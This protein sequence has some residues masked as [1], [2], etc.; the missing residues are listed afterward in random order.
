MVV[1]ETWKRFSIFASTW[2]LGISTVCGYVTDSE[3]TTGTKRA[4]GDFSGWSAKTGELP[5]TQFY[6][7]GIYE[8]K[9]S[10]GESLIVDEKC[11]S[12]SFAGGTLKLGFS[13]QIGYLYLIRQ[14]PEVLEVENADGLYLV[15]G[16]LVCRAK[17]RNAKFALDGLLTVNPSSVGRVSLFLGDD[18]STLRVNSKIRSVSGNNRPLYIGGTNLLFKSWT[19]GNRVELVG[20][21]SEFN[22]EIRLWTKDMESGELTASPE[23]TLALGNIV[24]PCKVTVSMNGQLEPLEGKTATVDTVHF[25]GN[26]W[27]KCTRNANK[28]S[29]GKIT[30]RNEL[31]VSGGKVK[32]A[33]PR[34]PLY[35]GS[36]AVLE[37]PSSSDV[38]KDDFVL[39]EDHNTEFCTLDFSDDGE[40]KTLY[41]KYEGLP[42]PINYVY[43]TVSSATLG[44]SESWSDETTSA[45]SGKHY[46]LSSEGL[47]DGTVSAT[48]KMPADVYKYDF[49]GD[50]LMIDTG[51]SLK[52][53][54][55]SKE[56]VV[57]SCDRLDLMDGSSI[58]GG[59]QIP[60]ELSGEVINIKGTVKIGSA[61]GRRIKIHSKI[62]GLGCLRLCGHDSGSVPY[63]TYSLEGNNSDFLG[64]IN[65][66]MLKSA[67]TTFD[68]KFS[69]LEVASANQ[70][71]GALSSLN[72]T[73]LLL[74]NYAKV[75]I[76][77]SFVLGKTSNRGVHIESGAQ[78]LVDKNKNGNISFTMETPLSLNG[79]LRKFG[80]GELVLKGGAMGFGNNGL[81]DNPTEGMNIISVRGGTLAVGSAD[82]INGA[83]VTFES[84]T[85]FELRP[86]FNDPDLMSYGIRNDKASMPFALGEN[87][88][89]LPFSIGA[90]TGKPESGV[91]FRLGLFT[92]K[93]NSDAVA[94][95]RQAVADIK[96]PVRGFKNKLVEVVDEEAE[97]VTFAIDYSPVGFCVSIR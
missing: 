55:Q 13:A 87:V 10:T 92:I 21:C 66:T 78:M 94:L 40:V 35:D 19:T 96:H 38:G 5:S 47:T 14:M 6:T 39:N 2:I 88:A 57:F 46:A 83:S 61:S 93:K 49:P 85:K 53:V 30:V 16:G 23:L 34:A 71:G 25:K 26:N 75:V 86:N 56:P 63:S 8:V 28:S 12:M 82:A 73:A 89:V 77:K 11:S 97:T 76:L 7:D 74:N 4:F 1:Q 22:S 31:A 51:C 67:V 27:L 91:P 48:L 42:E 84:G 9:A 90:T 69:I 15:N 60:L 80:V 64:S 33:V 18:N 79:E 43:Q 36:Y 17:A 20:D 59:S 44:E 54:Q 41:L 37:F 50:S 72:R 65:M 68:E 32:V 3:T 45:Q 62:A 81:S 95:V 29:L 52:F 70:L 24:L 58:G